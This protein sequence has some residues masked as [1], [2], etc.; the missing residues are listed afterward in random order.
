MG[1]VR[2]IAYACPNVTILLFQM[3]NVTA[4]MVYRMN[5]FY[6]IERMDKDIVRITIV[7]QSKV[8]DAVK[9]IIRKVNAE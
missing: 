6:M 1:I 3:T 9:K 8:E 4:I 2:I 5:T 7:K